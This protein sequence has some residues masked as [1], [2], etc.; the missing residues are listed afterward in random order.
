MRRGAFPAPR[1][2]IGYDAAVSANASLVQ[3]VAAGAVATPAEPKKLNLGCGESK[4]PGYVNVDWQPAV[5]PDVL[6]DLNRLPYPFADD[7]FDVIEAFHVIEH[8]D[9]PFAVMKELHRILK[10]GGKLQVKVPHF[11]RGFTHAEHAHGFDVT[12]PLY[13]NRNFTRSGYMG[14]ELTLDRMELHYIAFI[15]LLKHV[16]Y[17]GARLRLVR[18]LDAVVSFAANLNPYLASRLWCFWLGGFDEIEFRFTKPGA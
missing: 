16:G 17:G 15:H 1:L 4:K 3:P 18:A 12:F 10:P 2:G 8:L 14:F 6:H 7:T 13:F 11:S 9:R 5:E